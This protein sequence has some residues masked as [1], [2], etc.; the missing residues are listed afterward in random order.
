M[1]AVQPIIASHGVV[2]IAKVRLEGRSKERRK[3]GWLLPGLL[4]NDYLPRV[5][6]Q[7]FL[8]DDNGD[9]ATLLTLRG[10]SLGKHTKW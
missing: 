9:N 5:S 10:K 2:R 6:R 7:S 1:K 3:D 4:A 8:S